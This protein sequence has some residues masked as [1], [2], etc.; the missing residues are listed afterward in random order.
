[1][2][3]VQLKAQPWRQRGIL[4]GCSRIPHHTAK[5]PK[6]WGQAKK[7]RCDVIFTPALFVTFSFSTRS[8]IRPARWN[9]TY[10]YARSRSS[11]PSVLIP[12]GITR[13]T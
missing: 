6:W 11:Q 7:L 12:V 5:G 8:P 1:M 4:R 10:A 13:V 9:N 3:R 2:G